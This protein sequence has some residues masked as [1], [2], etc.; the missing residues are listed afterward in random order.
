MP[1]PGSDAQEPSLNLAAALERGRHAYRQR[2]W[3]DAFEALASADR[4]VP[5]ATDDLEMLAWSAALIGRADELLRVLERLY[6]TYVE[7][8]ANPRAAR[9]AFWLGFRLAALG[10]MGRAGGWLARA[11]RL[12][13]LEDCAEQGYVRLAIGSR[14]LASGDYETALAAGA[15]VVAIGER[16][17]EA[18]LVAFGRGLKGRALLRQGNVDAGLALLDETMIAATSGE[19]SPV[20]TGLIY[21]GVLASY[22]LVQALDRAREWTVALADWCEAQPQLVSF[23]GACRV[24]RAEIMQIGGAWAEAIDEADRAAERCARA[25]D[26]EGTANALYQKA[27]IHRLRGEF[28]KAEEDY[29]RAHQAGREPQPGLALLRL[30]Q[31]RADAASSAIRRVL[32]ATTDRWQRT[33]LLPAAVEIM[34]TLGSLDEARAASRELSQLAAG[35]GTEVF[36]AVAAQAEGTVELAAG[37]ASGAL[38]PLRRAFAVWQKVRAP[39]LAARVRVLLARA[40]RALGDEDGTRLELEQ[41]RAAFERLGAAP[42]VTAVDASAAP[43]RTSANRHGLTAR[44]LEVLRLVAAG[45]TNK[46][47]GKELHLSEKTIDRHVSNIFAKLKVPSRAAATAYAYENKLL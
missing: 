22:Q 16:H 20:V 42:D 44:E 27:E 39:Y 33:A 14:A 13:H 2:A 45:K 25:V 37:N 32:G 19:L 40:C 5:L 29:R 46:T 11:E 35:L 43:A 41:A 7:M 10:E 18:D 9:A 23:S 12:A 36:H 31:G 17:R 3:A 38:E 6:Q 34:V 21:C 24:H 47:I 28:E 15:D 4:A 1:T 30:A 26:R 8:G